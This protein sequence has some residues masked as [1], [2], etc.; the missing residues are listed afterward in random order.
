M[1]RVVAGVQG[2]PVPHYRIGEREVQFAELRP[3]LQQVFASR[4]DRTLFVQGDPG[5]T[6]GQIATVIGEGR[7]AGAGTVAL[8]GQTH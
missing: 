3:A 1:V 6:Y 5:L 2:N 8:L 4:Q 7:A